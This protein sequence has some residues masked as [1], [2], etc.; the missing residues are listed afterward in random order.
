MAISGILV[1][2]AL[3]YPQ[4]GETLSNPGSPSSPSSSASLDIDLTVATLFRISGISDLSFGSYSGS[5][6]LSRDD[7]VCV[8]TN[9]SGGSYRITARGS[10]GSFAFLVTKSGDD[11]RTIPYSVRWN[12]T[13]GTTGNAAIAANVTSGNL[14]GANTQSSSCS[15]GPAST[16]NFQV[17]FAQADLLSSPSGTYT[18]TLTLIVSAPT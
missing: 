4:L 15:S 14:F 13:S 1:L 3:S 12:T 7:D 18:G 6:P 17:T 16:G 8:W 5:G 2:S 10:G 9:A 11:S